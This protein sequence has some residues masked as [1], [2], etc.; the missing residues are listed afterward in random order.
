MDG[1]LLNMCD[2]FIEDAQKTAHLHSEKMFWQRLAA[3]HG[4]RVGGRNL[5]GAS[6]RLREEEDRRGFDIQDGRKKRRYDMSWSGVL[7][8]EG[9]LDVVEMKELKTEVARLF[10]AERGA[11]FQ[12]QLDARR[13]VYPL[14]QW[15]TTTGRDVVGVCAKWIST[16]AK[17]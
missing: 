12:E 16:T 10:R 7:V 11:V 9:M 13:R 15:S 6:A 2:L 14:V 4:H 17:T 3:K 8:Q 5:D 1:N